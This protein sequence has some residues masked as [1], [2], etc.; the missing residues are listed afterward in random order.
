MEQAD[1][2]K[3]IRIPRSAMQ[4]RQSSNEE[5]SS[6]RAKLLHETFLHLDFYVVEKKIS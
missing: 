4:A 2:W 6:S 1:C 5:F 3:I